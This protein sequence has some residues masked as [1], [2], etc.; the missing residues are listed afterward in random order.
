[1]LPRVLELST[2]LVASGGP[3]GGFGAR[4]RQPTSL[5]GQLEPARVPRRGG[6]LER[7]AGVAQISASELIGDE[8]TDERGDDHAGDETAAMARDR[9]TKRAEFRAHGG[10]RHPTEHTPGCRGTSL[11][12]G[13]RASR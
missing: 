7:R 5:L 8:P 1:L 9:A 13:G 4:P 11:D 10:A 2:K 12:G 3:A 6:L